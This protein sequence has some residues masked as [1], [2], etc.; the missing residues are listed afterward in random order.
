MDATL[1]GL[2][3]K[4][5]E[6][7]QDASNKHDARAGLKASLTADVEAILLE[8]IEAI[9][10]EMVVDSDSDSDFSDAQELTEEEKKNEKLTLDLHMAQKKNKDLLGGFSN[11]VIAEAA[12]AP[13]ATPTTGEEQQAQL[14]AEKEEKERIIAKMTL[15]EEALR[16]AESR[17]AV[18]RQAATDAE[19]AAASA[20]PPAVAPSTQHPAPTAAE[21]EASLFTQWATA[22]VEGIT[23]ATMP[24]LV[25]KKDQLAT[26]ADLQCHLHLW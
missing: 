2:R 11:A 9:E 4:V 16:Q 19:A 17:E 3:Q 22:F 26:L 12:S 13:A 14:E 6:L 18:L 1:A 21:T 25:A 7:E 15:V 5:N 10:A 23:P 8:K 24:E 20:P